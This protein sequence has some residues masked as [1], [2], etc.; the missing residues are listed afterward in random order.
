MAIMENGAWLI[1]VHKIIYI[2]IYHREI[3]IMTGYHKIHALLR[4][5]L[6]EISLFLQLT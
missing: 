6:L 2:Y 4:S 5:L 1:H 3:I